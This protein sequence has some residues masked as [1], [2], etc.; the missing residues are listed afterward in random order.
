MTTQISEEARHKIF[1]QANEVERTIQSPGWLLIIRSMNRDLLNELSAVV[2][3]N[4]EANNR[5]IAI[6]HK[7][8]ALQDITNNAETIISY[9]DRMIDSDK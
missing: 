9:R 1:T 2:G 6:T 3:H 8:T 5:R 4:E 7:M